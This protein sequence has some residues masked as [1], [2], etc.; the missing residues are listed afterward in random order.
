MRAVVLAVV[1]A[2]GGCVLFLDSPEGYELSPDAGTSRTSEGGASGSLA[3]G[4]LSTRDC[5]G[6]GGGGVCCVNL[7]S[8]SSA[9]SACQPA[10][11]CG[12]AIPVQLCTT[13]DECSGVPCTLQSCSLAGSA[14]TLRACGTIPSCTPR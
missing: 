1:L 3:L 4:C 11:P 2:T 5:A 8:T 12:G 7:A 10:G 9:T 6:D 14:V 13:N